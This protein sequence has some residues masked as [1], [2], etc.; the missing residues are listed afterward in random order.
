MTEANFNELYINQRKPVIL[1]GCQDLWRAKN[2]TFE[3][4]LN[5][6]E[7]K[8][9][10]QYCRNK[11]MDCKSSNL[12]G[13]KV[14]DLIRHGYQVKVFN[15][16]PKSYRGWTTAEE[17]LSFK[18]DLLEEY[19]FPSP[20]PKDV[21]ESI[22]AETDQ[23]YIMLSTNGTGKYSTL[24]WVQPRNSEL[25]SS[26]YSGMFQAWFKLQSN[27]ERATVLSIQR[28]ATIYFKSSSAYFKPC[29][30]LF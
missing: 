18:V 22:H 30:S 4:L 2:W 21:F 10:T 20:L 26:L 6:Y 1:K 14:Q 12:H 23:A 5:R 29:S 27:W 7:S 17:Y 24:L 13:W 8:W 3:N 15:K 11:K 16:L 19:D 9:F 28:I 25:G